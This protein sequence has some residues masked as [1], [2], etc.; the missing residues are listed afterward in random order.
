[1]ARHII[2]L[3]LHVA[4]YIMY[5]DADADAAEDALL[6]WEDKPVEIAGVIRARRSR[7]LHPDLRQAL[8]STLERWLQQRD[9]VAVASVE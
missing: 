3:T 6:V 5:S 4:A 7:T 2:P 1:M 9:I 8:A